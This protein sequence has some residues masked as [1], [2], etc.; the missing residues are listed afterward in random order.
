MATKDRGQPPRRAGSRSSPGGGRSTAATERGR[1]ARPPA[2]RAPT[3]E[4]AQSSATGGPKTPA[5]GTHRRRARKTVA[6]EAEGL[7]AASTAEEQA[8]SPSGVGPESAAASAAHLEPEVPPDV[9]GQ[10]ETRSSEEALEEPA[11]AEVRR[12]RRDRHRTAH[13]NALGL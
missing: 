5:E 1:K 4:T 9:L 3:G 10:A 8:V 13:A 7:P 12:A 11:A 6:G 2:D